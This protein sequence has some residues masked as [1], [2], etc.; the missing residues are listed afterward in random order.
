MVAFIGR[1]TSPCSILRT[2]RIITLLSQ[3]ESLLLPSLLYS[4]SSPLTPSPRSSPFLSSRSLLRSYGGS[5]LVGELRTVA[6]FFA[7]SQ[8]PGQKG[9]A[10]SKAGLLFNGCRDPVA[11][12]R[13]SPTALSPLFSLVG[14]SI[15]KPTSFPQGFCK[16]LSPTALSPPKLSPSNKC[17]TSNAQ[18][19]LGMIRD[20]ISADCVHCTS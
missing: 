3:E 4:L 2:S 7:Y 19:G 20:A 18:G 5:S 9:A 13:F 15:A 17:K 1:R 8:K 10:L 11:R 14:L 16:T 6:T 12:V